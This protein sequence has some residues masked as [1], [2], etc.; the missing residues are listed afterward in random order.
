MRQ[1][2]AHFEG[3]DMSLV[4]VSRKLKE[5]LKVEELLTEAGVDYAVEP[6]EY[7][8]T[9]LFLIPVARIG[10]FFYVPAERAA[11]ARELLRAGGFAVSED[12]D[13]DEDA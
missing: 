2:P 1:D 11:G 4:H 13:E 6:D 9:W 3:R 7:R 12:E 10:A 8:G 5:A